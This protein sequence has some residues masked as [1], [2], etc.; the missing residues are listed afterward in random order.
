[1]VTPEHNTDR[2]VAD[3]LARLRRQITGEVVL[4]VPYGRRSIR[5]NLPPHVARW[6]HGELSA[7][8][9]EQPAAPPRWRRTVRLHRGQWGQSCE[10]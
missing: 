10:Q 1:M 2:A 9:R 5:V 4:V 7:A 8:I 3:E 6:L